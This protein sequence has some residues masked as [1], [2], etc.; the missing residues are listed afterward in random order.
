MARV[1]PTAHSRCS[2][3]RAAWMRQDHGG[4]HVMRNYW[5][6]AGVGRAIGRI[7]GKRRSSRGSIEV[8]LFI[9]VH[10]PISNIFTSLTVAT[11]H[12]YRDAFREAETIRNKTGRPVVVFLDEIDALCPARTREG[13]VFA[14]QSVA[15]VLIYTVRLV[16]TYSLPPPLFTTEANPLHASWRNC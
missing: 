10:V 2:F 14:V 3:A 8:T 6:R 7:W 11:T 13:Y 12:V 4:P 9:F 15:I 1:Q 5:E 16:L